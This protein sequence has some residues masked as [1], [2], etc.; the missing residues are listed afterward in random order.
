MADVSDADLRKAETR[1]KVMLTSEP[2]AKSARYDLTTGRIVVDLVNGCSYAFPA[3]LVQDLQN[4]SDK[5]LSDV[6]V[7]DTVIRDLCGVAPPPRSLG[8]DSA[9]G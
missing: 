2:R 3:G 7:G 6:Q 5:A 4:A 9:G 1:G 8:R